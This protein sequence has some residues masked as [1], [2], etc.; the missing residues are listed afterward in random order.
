MIC[1]GTHRAACWPVAVILEAGGRQRERHRCAPYLNATVLQS[2]TLKHPSQSLP[3]L[4]VR[5]GWGQTWARSHW[6]FAPEIPLW[7]CTSGWRHPTVAGF[8]HSVT[9]SFL[10][11]LRPLKHLWDSIT[12]A[13]T[14]WKSGPPCVENVCLRLM[15]RGLT[16]TQLI[17][18]LTI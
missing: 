13:C 5:W 10:C 3:A 16:V 9:I 18:T 4:A 11:D 14:V 6:G 7:A 15:G 8:C 17:F 2:S 1:A 12:S